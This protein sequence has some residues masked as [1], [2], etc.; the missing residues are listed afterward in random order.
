MPYKKIKYNRKKKYYKK[1]TATPAQKK[2]FNQAKRTMRN[3]MYTTRLQNKLNSMTIAH[4]YFGSK[5]INEVEEAS[6]AVV[7]Q[8]NASADELPIVVCSLR[9]VR[10]N[11]HLPTQIM[12]LEQDGYSF[13]NINDN[14]GNN[15]GEVKHLGTSG[16]VSNNADP[17]DLKYR[18]LLHRYT[19]IK[20]LLWQNPKRDSTY[21]I[22]LIQIKDPDLNPQITGF[23]TNLGQVVKDKR[24]MFWKYL[25]LRSLMSNPIISGTE[26][27]TKGIKGGYKVIW[28]KQYHLEE[29]HNDYDEN[30]YKQ[31][32]IFRRFDKVIN[33]NKTPSVSTSDAS[34]T[35]IRDPETIV[36]SDITD[37]VQGIPQ[38]TQDDIFLV[39]SSNCSKSQSEAAAENDPA[40]FDTRSFDILIK[41]KYSSTIDTTTT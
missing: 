25:Q 30:S 1:R 4:H 31:V 11:S 2:R 24:T 10:N 27:L 21:K 3:I 18:R 28:S 14:N 41:S 34:E 15:A 23:S 13:K 40:D 38:Y 12:K 20:L 33:Y 36:W 9:A 5:M 37:D 29:R 17:K 39:I 7:L 32:N 35:A 19:Q 6:G 22:Q 8:D 26:N 16:N